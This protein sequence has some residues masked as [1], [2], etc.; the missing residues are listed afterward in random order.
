[1]DLNAVNPAISVIIPVWN[2]ARYL[3]EAFD[4]IRSQSVPDLEVIV[5]DDESTDETAEIAKS[6]AGVTYVRQMRSGQSAARNLGV[7]LSRGRFL[8]FLD[9]DDLWSRSKLELQLAQFD[10]RGDLDAVFG[11]AIQFS[12]RDECGRI[13]PV[14]A[15][16]PAHLPGAMLI[17]RASFDRVGPYSSAWQ[18]GEVL[19]WYAR[20]VDCGLSM[21]T[22]DEVVLER[23]LHDQNLGVTARSP[24]GDYLK[25]VRAVLE[26]RRKGQS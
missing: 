1:L 13:V 19:D 23:R 26:R 15:K 4:R 5:V 16:M 6:L 14:G 20:A 2:G 17:R 24:A 21:V 10:R 11:H 18:V 3:R 8:A 12:S 7:S 25:V 22:I 9:A